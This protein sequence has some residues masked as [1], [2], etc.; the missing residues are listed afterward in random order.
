MVEAPDYSAL[1]QGALAVSGADLCVIS[2]DWAWTWLVLRITIDERLGRQRA[3]LDLFDHALHL[4]AILR[5]WVGCVGEGLQ[6]GNGVFLVLTEQLQFGDLFPQ[7]C[8]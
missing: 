1:F 2:G 5:A 3:L 7:V 6:A 8:R 4:L